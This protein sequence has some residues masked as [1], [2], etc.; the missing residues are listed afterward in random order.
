MS[1]T[2]ADHEALL[3]LVAA[4]ALGT[5]D[6]EE[7]RIVSAHLAVCPQC[8]GEY[9]ALRPA[10]NAVALSSEETVLDDLRS[11]RMKR[12]I[13][14]QIQA[15]RRRLQPTLNPTRLLGI[16]LTLAAVMALAFVEADSMRRLRE[17]TA[18]LAQ[19]R[20][21]LADLR[22]Q[23]ARSFQ[24]PH[25]EILRTRDSVYIVLQSM[26]PPAKGHVYQAW[27]LAP[28]AKAVA[29][30]I[31]FVPDEQGFVA[32]SLPQPSEK[33]AAVAVSVEPTGGS[34][35]PTTKPAF[36]RTLD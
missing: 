7:A 22:L 17:T 18:Q 36:I 21:L 10:A 26:P 6:A 2:S 29:P 33:I 1:P 27:T 20:A 13:F 11:R 5:V 31:T 19:D 3:D 16:G 32:V 35:S 23:S 30:S 15:P 28:G 14:E 9:R 24:V 25:G 8:R 34:R 12:R 4:Y